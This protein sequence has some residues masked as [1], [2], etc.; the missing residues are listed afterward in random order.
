MVHRRDM[1]I[2]ILEEEEED[3]QSLFWQLFYFTQRKDPKILDSF[4]KMVKWE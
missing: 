2:S 4:I 1:I 3:Y